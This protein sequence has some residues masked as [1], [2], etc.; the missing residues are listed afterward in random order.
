MGQNTEFLHVLSPEKNL[1]PFQNIYYKELK[2][3]MSGALGS[4]L[5]TTKNIVCAC[6]RVVCKQKLKN[7]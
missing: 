5:I 1:Y 4:I 2:L 3:E 7:P 6:V